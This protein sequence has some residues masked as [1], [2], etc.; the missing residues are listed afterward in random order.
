MRQTI[1]F[2]SGLE[3]Q[4]GGDGQLVSV[5][6]VCLGHDL[7]PLATKRRASARSRNSLCTNCLDY[8]GPLH[9]K[10]IFFARNMCN[11]CVPGIVENHDSPFPSTYR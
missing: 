6:N 7:R 5:L 10:G 2:S 3:R 9:L 8:H 11:T 1:C 4:I